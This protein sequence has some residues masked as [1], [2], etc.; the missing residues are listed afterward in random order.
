MTEENKLI[1]ERKKKLDAIKVNNKAYPNTFRK[2][3]YANSISDKYKDL[4]KEDIAEKNIPVSIAGRLLTIRNMGNS[5]FANLH[6]ESGNIQIYLQKKQVGEDSYL[7]F[8]NLDLGDIVGIE[9]VLFKTKTGELTVNTSS[10]ILLS[11][12]LRPLPEKF[13]GIADIEIKYRQRYLDLMINPETK[14]LF[15]TRSKIVSEIRNFFI[16]DDYLE[17]ET[18]M[19]HMIPGGA[20]AKPFITHHN[21]LDLN[22]YLRIAPELFLKRCIIGGYEKVFEINRSFRNEGLSVK[23]NPEFTMIEFYCA[24]QDYIYLMSLIENLFSKIISSLN[25]SSNFKYQDLQINFKTPFTKIKFYDSI[26]KYA[27]GIDSS[28]FNDKKYIEDYCSE[29][30]IKI[31]DK[32]SIVKMHLDIFDK[33]VEKELINP[34]FV[35]HYPTEVSPLSRSFDDEPN[36]VE[37]FELFIAG[38]EIANGFSELNDPEEQSNRFKEQVNSDDDEKMSYDE[39][40]VTALEYGM[41]PTAGAGIGIDRLIMIFTDSASIRDVLLFPHMKPKK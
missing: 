32:G 24:Y 14:S 37:R 13:H 7:L 4:E 11:K 23:H 17:V 40:F 6:D 21:S 18:P 22:L 2:K 31:S 12:S 36:L 38:R 5:S 10:I 34:T 1:T 19:M 30:S 35:T 33:M 26:E 20:A 25:F 29:N 39:D 16:E 28:K 3:D 41:P 15:K 27:E 8:N 9:G